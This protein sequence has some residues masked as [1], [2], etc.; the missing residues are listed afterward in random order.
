MPQRTRQAIG[1]LPAPLR[2]TALRLP[3]KQMAAAEEL[4]LRVGQPLVVQLDR[5]DAVPEPSS[6]LSAQDLADTLT[7]AAQGSAHT[8]MEQ[9]RHGFFTAEGGHRV[10]LAGAAL[11]KG[12][13]ISG[14]RE[15]SSL[16]IRVA[17][18]A[19]GIADS[20]CEGLWRYGPL[21]NVLIL[22]PPGHGK[23]T[24]LREMV[25]R[26]SHTRT[27]A[28]ADERGEVAGL[29]RGR[30]SMDVGARTDVLSG[31]PKATAALCLL[32]AMTPQVL[33]MDE[34]TDPDD[35]NALLTCVGCGVSLICTAHAAH[36][37][38]FASRPVNRPLLDLFERVIVINRR[39]GVRHYA[40]ECLSGNAER[41]C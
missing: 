24:L 13:E 29:V 3:D 28:L 19:P 39:E 33:A 11:V 23:T 36:F 34:I 30:P 8:A 9:T 31:A 10:G 38:D 20:L 1:L 32:R 26:I 12:G 27:V 17:R 41:V 14:F 35:V 40:M 22:S 5:T 21:P 25:R 6:L 4:R 18:P 2:Q 15:L 37:G 7:Q 16:C